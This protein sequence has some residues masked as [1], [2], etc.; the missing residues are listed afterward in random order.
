M[1]P[2]LVGVDLFSSFRCF[3]WACDKYSDIEL[4][5]FTRMKYKSILHKGGKDWENVYVKVEGSRIQ[6]SLGVQQGDCALSNDV[7]IFF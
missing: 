3:V 1:E 7:F 5:P 6:K 2:N 4:M